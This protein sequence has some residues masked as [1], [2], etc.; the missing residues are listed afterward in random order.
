MAE[1]KTGTTTKKAPIAAKAATPAAG[2]AKTTAK[3]AAKKAPARTPG[4]KAVATKPKAAKLKVTPEQRHFMIAEAAYFRAER[5]GF[6]GGYEW[7]DW[8]DAEAE[9]ERMRSRGTWTKDELVELFNRMIPEFR[10]KETGKYLD[11]KM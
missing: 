4:T 1:S 10:H 9:I 6:E 5:R 8:M 3:P 2:V 11:Q 7:Q